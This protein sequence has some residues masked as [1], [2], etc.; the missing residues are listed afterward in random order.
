MVAPY[1]R[2]SATQH[3][4]EE[5]RAVIKHLERLIER[6]RGHGLQLQEQYQEEI[7]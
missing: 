1:S 6:E 2:L 4:D 5:R 7:H 3:L